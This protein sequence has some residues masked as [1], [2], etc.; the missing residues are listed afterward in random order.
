[1]KSTI[2]TAAKVVEELN[3]LNENSGTQR[4]HRANKSMITRVFQEKMVK[5]SNAWPVYQK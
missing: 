1:M 5:Q 4:R 2:K 3:Q